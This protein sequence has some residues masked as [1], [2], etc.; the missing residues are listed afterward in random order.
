MNILS[1]EPGI[2]DVYESTDEVYCRRSFCPRQDLK[3]ILEGSLEQSFLRQYELGKS[4]IDPTMIGS[5]VRDITNAWLAPGGRRSPDIARRLLRAT[6]AFTILVMF[7]D[8]MSAW[9]MFGSK[10]RKAAAGFLYGGALFSIIATICAFAVLRDGIFQAYQKTDVYREAAIAIPAA[11]IAARFVFGC[12]V[13]KCWCVKPEI[14]PELLAAA[15]AAN[16]SRLP[17][18]KQPRRKRLGMHGV[19]QQPVALR[20]TDQGQPI[21]TTTSRPDNE[22]EPEFFGH[23][24]APRGYMPRSGNANPPV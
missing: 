8:A 13:H 1:W 6:A 3:A 12:F 7:T 21:S 23:I 2:C 9:A 14:D 4:T 11:G 20:G 16:P 10:Q 24:E 19:I 17:P 15:R 18:P 22:R 5:K